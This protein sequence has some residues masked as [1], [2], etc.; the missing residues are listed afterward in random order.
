MKLFHGMANGT[1]SDAERRYY[2]QA[3]RLVKECGEK[4]QQPKRFTYK[5]IMCRQLDKYMVKS[6]PFWFNGFVLY[7]PIPWL[8][9][10]ISC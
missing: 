3:I 1:V 5:M 8:S 9:L 10:D 2:Y 7:V 4:R 6:I